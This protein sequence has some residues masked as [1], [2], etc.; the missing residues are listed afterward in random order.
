MEADENVAVM[1]RAYEAFNTGDMDTLNELFDDSVVWHLP[2]RSTFAN[3]YQGRDA[4]LGYFGQLAEKAF[5]VEFPAGELTRDT[6]RRHARA[7]TQVA[8]AA[9][10]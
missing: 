3:D 4:T 8:I 2:G 9:K 1:R 6:V 7:V 10:P 5:V